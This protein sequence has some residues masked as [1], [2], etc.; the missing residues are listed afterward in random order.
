MNTKKSAVW[1][2]LQSPSARAQLVGAAFW[3]AILAASLVR[4][5]L[6]LQQQESEVV[7][8]SFETFET[9]ETDPARDPQRASR[10]NA[11]GGTN[12][13]EDEE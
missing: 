10:S 2:S 6:R 5:I 3:L 1:E 11:A 9:F 4:Q 13:W 12:M 8:E 7:V